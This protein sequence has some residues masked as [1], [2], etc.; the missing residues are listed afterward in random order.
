MSDVHDVTL[1]GFTPRTYDFLAALV[2]DHWGHPMNDFTKPS[3][4]PF[5][6]AAELFFV[7]RAMPDDFFPGGKWATIQHLET[8]IDTQAA[9]AS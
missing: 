2:E 6:S 5:G 9:E 7:L 8:L 3:P 1:R 4:I